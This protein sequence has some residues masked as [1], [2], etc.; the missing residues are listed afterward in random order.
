MKHNR[1][2]AYNEEL[3]LIKLH[4]PSI[5][6]F[7][8]VT[9][10]IRYFICPLALDPMDTKHGKAVTYSEGLSPI[11]LH[12]PLNMWSIEVRWQIR[13]STFLLS[14]CLWSPNSSGWKYTVRDSHPYRLPSHGPSMKWYCDVMLQ[15]KYIFLL[16]EDPWTPNYANCRFTET[17]TLKVTWPFDHVT[18]WEIYI[19]TFTRLLTTKLGRVVTLG[20]RFFKRSHHQVLVVYIV[21]P[22]Y[23]SP[24]W[25]YSTSPP[26]P[27]Y[28]SLV[29]YFFTV[30]WHCAS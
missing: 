25:I 13:N 10:Q 24:Y 23:F 27:H 11:N 21:I 12:N 7:C 28:L 4:D 8:E 22:Y 17:P 6:W 15:I 3:S 16:A 9:R 20:R 18:I 14:Q 30:V 19:S 5:T 2:V 29:F 26:L 1:V